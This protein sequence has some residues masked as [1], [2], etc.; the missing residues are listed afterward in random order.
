MFLETIQA[1][2]GGGDVRATLVWLLYARALEGDCTTVHLHI[3]SFRQLRRELVHL[4]IYKNTLLAAEVGRSTFKSVS[5][6]NVQNRI[7]I[8]NF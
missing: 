7:C 5:R 3:P 4:P 8:F 2:N 6:M 1:S